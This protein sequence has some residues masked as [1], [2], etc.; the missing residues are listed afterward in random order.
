MNPLKNAIRLLKHDYFFWLQ[1]YIPGILH[2]VGIG[3]GASEWVTGSRE[4]SGLLQDVVS[5]Q[6]HAPKHSLPGS[7]ALMTSSTVLPSLFSGCPVNCKK[8]SLGTQKTD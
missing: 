7:H 3:W 6:G 8:L 5:T 1:V 2:T 4:G